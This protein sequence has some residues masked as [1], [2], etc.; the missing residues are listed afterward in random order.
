VTLNQA[1]GGRRRFVLIQQ[2]EALDAGSPHQR[3][4]AAFCDRLG[5]PRSIEELTKERLRRAGASF[6]TYELVDE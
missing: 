3:A 2:A 4:A 6:R 5:R 1:D